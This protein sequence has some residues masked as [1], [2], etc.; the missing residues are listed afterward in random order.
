MLPELLTR[1][2]AYSPKSRL[3]FLSLWKCLPLYSEVRRYS[4]LPYSSSDMEADQTLVVNN[5]GIVMVCTF[6]YVSRYFPIRSTMKEFISEPVSGEDRMSMNDFKPI[7]K[8]KTKKTKT[9]PREAP[10]VP[11]YAE[12][13]YNPYTEAEDKSRGS[14]EDKAS[15]GYQGQYNRDLESSGELSW[16]APTLSY[17]SQVSD[18]T[19]PARTHD[20]SNHSSGS[21]FGRQS[22]RASQGIQALPRLDYHGQ[23]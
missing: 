19:R 1:G 16:V 9:S 18:P 20:K 17:Q 14:F 12:Y 13:D 23:R 5:P 7:N 2:V 10:S 3:A 22:R 4:F 11:A 15:Y 8:P 6:F 21:G